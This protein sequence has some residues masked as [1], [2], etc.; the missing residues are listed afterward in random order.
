MAWHLVTATVTVKDGER[1]LV[2][3]DGRL[4]RVLEPGRHALFD[5]LN[6]L[7]EIV[8]SRCLRACLLLPSQWY[9]CNVSG[10]PEQGQPRGREHCRPRDPAPRIAGHGAPT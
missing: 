6:R 5:P 3:R 2:M 9:P 10:L 7:T 1:A 8:G 4:A